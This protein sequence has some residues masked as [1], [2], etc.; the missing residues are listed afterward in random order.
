MDYK[1]LVPIE[2]DKPLQEK[3][4]IL[5]IFNKS[6]TANLPLALL[7]A[8]GVQHRGQQ[9]A[10]IALQY[11]KTMKQFAGNGLLRDVFKPSVIQ[12]LNKPS[13]WTLI[14][15]RYGT[16]GG[17]DKRNLQPCIVT[18]RE[19]E[20]IAI[21]HN[22][23]FVATDLIKKK[24]SKKFPPDISDT[25]LFA[26]LLAETEGLTWEH[27]VIHALSQVDG[28][29][30]LMIGIK[31][32]LFIARDRSGLRPLVIGQWKDK[33]IVASETH[34]LSKIGAFIIREVKR[35]EIACIDS[36]GLTIIKHGETSGTR[37]FCDFEWAYFGRP[38]SLVPT[39]EKEDDSKNPENWLALSSF[40]ERSGALIAKESPIYNAS[41]A[42]GMPDSGMAVAMGY[43]N[44]LHI[45][46]RQVII[47]DH[48]DPNGSQRLFM[49]D[50]QKKRIG[51]KV[52][53]KLSLIPDKNIWKNAIVVIGDDSIVRGNVTTRITKAIFAM[54]AKEVHW[55][56]GYPPVTHPCHLGVSIRTTAEL[57][58][59]QHNADPVKIAKKIK[60]TSV[61]YISPEAFIQARLLTSNI[62]K[63]KNPKDIF[64][65]NGG[66][67]GCVTGKY[68]VAKDGTVY[69]VKKSI[70][71]ESINNSLLKKNHPTQEHSIKIPVS[72]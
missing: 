35:G 62:K 54:G 39:H 47:R 65:H 36:K 17:Y 21:I 43:A 18:S 61:H 13:K 12:R 48:F 42:F 7:A 44:A 19:G 46:Y 40:R 3:C 34:A 41:F 10:G 45:P 56:I 64:L 33:W 15:C 38:E 72:I 50:D 28:A 70:N 8:G 37:H 49:R 1:T 16:H 5:A 14:H 67:G 11:K 51:K 2:E 52:L 69:E 63:T 29:Y 32:K 26:Q 71:F 27:R 9:G 55:I 68:P 22:G 30:S 20:K 24:I 59:S 60:A 31:N 25:Y 6:Y 4:G 23:E 57:I 53:G 66:C 58:A